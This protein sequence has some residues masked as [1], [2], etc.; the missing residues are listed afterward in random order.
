MS[1]GAYPSRETMAGWL[2]LDTL[3]ATVELSMAADAHGPG[4]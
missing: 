4:A 2:A 1:R 3:P